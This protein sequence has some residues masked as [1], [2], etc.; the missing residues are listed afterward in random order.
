MGRG[1]TH[2]TTRS[3]AGTLA[4][5]P[6]VSAGLTIRRHFIPLPFSGSALPQKR[7][8]GGGARGSAARISAAASL[9]ASMA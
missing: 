6:P 3:G 1:V 4:L 8:V 7:Q 9:P 5:S 2:Q